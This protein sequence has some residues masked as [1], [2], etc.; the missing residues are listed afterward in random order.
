MLAKA[1]RQGK[2]DILNKLVPFQDHITAP[3]N[4]PE[5]VLNNL[6]KH[7]MWSN[8]GTTLNRSG[9]LFSLRD[10]TKEISEIIQRW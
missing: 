6:G 10:S 3:N 4:G 8:Q 1:E 2:A 7:V 9:T 5:V